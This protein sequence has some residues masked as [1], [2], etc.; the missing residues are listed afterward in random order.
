MSASPLSSPEQPPAITEQ[1]FSSADSIQAAQGVFLLSP[2]KEVSA[3]GL[4][5]VNW[6]AHPHSQGPP[7]VKTPLSVQSLWP[8]MLSSSAL[9]ADGPQPLRRRWSWTPA[10]LWRREGAEA[11]AAA[12]KPRGAAAC[13]QRGAK[14]DF[15]VLWSLQEP[16]RQLTVSRKCGRK[17]YQT[18]LPL[19]LPKQLVIFGLGDWN[20][21]QK[22]SIAVEILVNPDVKSQRIGKLGP[23][24]RCLLWEGEWR[25]DVLMASLK[26]AESGNP[27][28]LLLTVKEKLL[29][30]TPA[31]PFRTPEPGQSP[32]LP[33][34][35]VSE[36]KGPDE[37][38]GAQC[39]R[40][41]PIKEIVLEEKEF[42]P[43]LETLLML[44]PPE[45][46]VIQ[47]ECEEATQKTCQPGPLS[48]QKTRRVLF[49]PSTAKGQEE[50]EACPSPRWCHAMCLSDPETAVLIGGEETNQQLCKDALWK[51]EIDDDFWFPMDFPGQNFMPQCP[52]GHTATYDPDTKRIYI[53][54]GLREGK[55]YSSIHVL[56]TTSWKWLR[57][58]AKGKVPT[59][60]YHS[61]NIYR[62]ELFVFGGAFPKIS[63]L[64][65]GACSNSLFIFNPEYEIWYQPI[66]EGEKPLPRFGHSGTLLRNKLI[67]FG[68]QMNS[69]YLNDTSILDLGF[70]EYTSVPFLSGQPSARSFHAAMSVSDQK[71]LISGGCNAKGAFQDAF[72]F[73]LDTLTWS[74]VVH[75]DLCSVPRAGHTL[76]NLTSAHLTDMDKESRGKCNLCTVLVFGGSDYAGKFYNSTSKIELDLGEMKGAS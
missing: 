72:T 4:P 13:A 26:Q 58:A 56:D 36:V 21:S 73:H 69:T 20:C 7:S 45:T 32:V 22:M 34:E 67:I 1:S 25:V 62:K 39:Q 27:V 14:L 68:G 61:A 52:R 6:L 15:Y 12:R 9:S 60:S 41:V 51:L 43:V 42:S 76:L 63:S 74:A 48:L 40:S 75:S 35:I 31:H 10:G 71:V 28:K 53:F 54:G 17:C 5:P 59:L 44:P 23:E 33:E 2:A 30:S 70:M 57:I 65:T 24:T 37:P 66:V 11:T 16:P 49:E 38:P 50:A 19:P 46:T 18:H 8:A 3:L 47:Q 55:H 29:N 64:E